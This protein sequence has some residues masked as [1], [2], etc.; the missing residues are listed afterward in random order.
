MTILEGERVRLLQPD[1]ASAAKVLEYFVRNKEHLAPWSPPRPA[2]FFTETYWAN[3]L[4]KNLASL[5]EGMSARF[6]IV[7][8]KEE[9]ILGACNLSDII[10]GAFQACHLGYSV[11]KDAQ[12][13]GIMG[14]ALELIIEY[15]FGELD[16]HRIEANYLPSNERSAKLLQR[17]GFEI[18]GSARDYLFIGGAWR[19]HVLTSL[20]NADWQESAQKQFTSEQ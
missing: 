13:Q 17:R 2:P 5:T 9:T 16:L 8:G 11:D 6:F 10:R 3:T 20:T 18:N 4:Q 1:P 19:D 14:E 7:S 12:G 15:A